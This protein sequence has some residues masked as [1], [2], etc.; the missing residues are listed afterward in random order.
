MLSKVSST[1][2]GVCGLLF[3]RDGV[4]WPFWNNFLSTT[5]PAS[6]SLGVSRHSHVNGILLIITL[7]LYQELHLSGASVMTSGSRCYMQR[8]SPYCWR[9]SEGSNKPLPCDTHWFQTTLK[10]GIHCVIFRPV[11]TRFPVVQ[12][13]LSLGSFSFFFFFCDL[14]PTLHLHYFT[15]LYLLHTYCMSE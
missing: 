6:R 15:L 8:V 4:H 14:T 9:L 2:R 12:N 10:P 13:F 3:A 5:T 1:L 7:E 11:L